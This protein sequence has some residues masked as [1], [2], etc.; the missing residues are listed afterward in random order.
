MVWLKDKKEKSINIVTSYISGLLRSVGSFFSKKVEEEIEE[1]KEND[2]ESCVAD[3]NCKKFEDYINYNV[4]PVMFYI[5][6]NIDFL[7]EDCLEEFKKLKYDIKIGLEIEFFSL[8]EI[9]DLEQFYQEVKNF[10]STNNIHIQNIEKERGKNQFEIQL[11]P[12]ID[13]N[14]LIFDFGKLK[15]FLNNSKYQITFRAVPFYY[16]VGSALQINITI[17]RDNKNLF[18]RIENDGVKEES[19]LL[20]NCIAGL[21]Y[22]TNSFLPLYTKSDNCFMRY[23]KEFGEVFY[24]NGKIPGPSF[25]SWGVNNRTCSIRIPTPKKFDNS[26]DY[27]S[28]DELNRRIEFRVPSSDSDIKLVLYGVLDSMLMGIANNLYPMEST[29]NNVFENNENY[30]KISMPERGLPNSFK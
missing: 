27:Y 24:K 8:V 3:C 2:E 23:K 15:N 1:E 13:L 21:I 16:E 19:E 7:I 10:S 11:E 28:E 4:T 14:K 20:K 17:N 6:N 5:K 9:Q 22:K 26:K 18:S 30:E 12:Y 29:M 25:N